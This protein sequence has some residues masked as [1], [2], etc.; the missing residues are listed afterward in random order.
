MQHKFL[1]AIVSNRMSISYEGKRRMDFEDKVVYGP[2]DWE[3]IPPDAMDY[4][5]PIIRVISPISQIWCPDD[6]FGPNQ[7]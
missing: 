7:R 5:L 4:L 6:H 3:P 1:A 2:S